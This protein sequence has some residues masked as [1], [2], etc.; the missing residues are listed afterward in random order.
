MGNRSGGDLVDAGMRAEAMARSARET[1]SASRVAPRLPERDAAWPPSPVRLVGGEPEL[2]IGARQPSTAR[3]SGR[4]G[5]QDLKA[6][7]D[8]YGRAGP[9]G[10]LVGEAARVQQGGQQLQ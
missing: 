9:P 7:A 6:R 3:A 1:P 10:R 8:P 5:G 4:G 2:T